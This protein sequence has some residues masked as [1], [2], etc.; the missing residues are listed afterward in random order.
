[1]YAHIISRHLPPS[2][3]SA[4]VDLGCGYG[5]FLAACRDHGYT[6]CLGVDLSDE[7]IAQSKILGLTNTLKSDISS[8]CSSEL[9]DESVDAFVMLDVL[10]HIPRDEQ[11]SFLSLVYRKCKPNARLIIRVPNAES[12]FALS[13]RYG[14]FTHQLAYTRVSLSQ[15]LIQAGFSSLKFQECRP[16]VHGIKSFTRSILWSQQ[17]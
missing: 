17:R 11:I 6:N 13:L 9:R 2:K 16:V 15:I 5:G 1:M 4:V 3:N 7:L 12:P 10:E 8:F 14:D